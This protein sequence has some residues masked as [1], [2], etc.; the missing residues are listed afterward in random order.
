MRWNL[1][2]WVAIGCAGCSGR[3]PAPSGPGT[4][5]ATA[6]PS[7][8][9]RSTSLD[10]SPAPAAAPPASVS[11]AASAPVAAETPSDAPYKPPFPERED[12]FLRPDMTKV[13]SAKATT[14]TETFDVRLKGFINVDGMQAL[15]V[16]DGKLIQVAEGDVREGI[17]VI[18]VAPPQ[19]V[20][21]RGRTRWTETLYKRTPSR[22]ER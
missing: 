9:V 13:A 14:G 20:L 16:L 3:A 15:L 1:L 7:T 4:T 5:I 12:P 21:Q 11:A 18:Q 17:Q 22:D 8:A 6:A 19:V 10:S 2:L